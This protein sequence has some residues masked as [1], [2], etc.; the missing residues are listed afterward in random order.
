VA[1]VGGRA[2][3]VDIWARLDNALNGLTVAPLA[4]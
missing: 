4:Q 2:H 1:F 3:L